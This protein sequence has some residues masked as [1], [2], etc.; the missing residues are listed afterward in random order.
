VDK[1]AELVR[2]PVR[3]ASVAAA[4]RRDVGEQTYAA[5]EAR[6]SAYADEHL[7]TASSAVG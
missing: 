5:F 4:G 2:D 6:W 3:S 1:L 7:V